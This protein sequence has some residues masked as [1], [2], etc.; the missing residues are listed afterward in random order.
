MSIIIAENA[1]LHGN[2]L[3]QLIV[4]VLENGFFQ[5]WWQQQ[6]IGILSAPEFIVSCQL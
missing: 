4:K 1:Y 5:I 3:Q 2:S 6:V